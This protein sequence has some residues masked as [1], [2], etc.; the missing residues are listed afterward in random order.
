M[1]R[2]LD[3]AEDAAPERLR[4]VGERGQFTAVF[5]DVDTVRVR[6]SGLGLRLADAAGGLTPFTGTFLFR[7]PQ[8]GAAVFTSYETG[9]RYRVTPLAGELSVIG[10]ELLGAG[11]RAVEVGGDGGEWEIAIEEVF[12]EPRPARP[13][14]DFHAVVAERAEEFT[15]FADAVAPWRDA[16]PGATLAAYVIW[17]AIGAPARVR[18][19]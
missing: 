12:S 3:V 1:A 16:H 19:T 9:R 15:A 8:D 14:R 7:A 13:T 17:S 10:A 4:W 6:G 5:A 18:H 2:P 11:E